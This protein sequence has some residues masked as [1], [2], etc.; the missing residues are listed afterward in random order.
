M[1]TYCNI[2]YVPKPWVNLYQVMVIHDLD[3]LGYHDLRN[4]MASSEACPSVRSKHTHISVSGKPESSKASLGRSVML[5][6]IGI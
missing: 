6:F 4:P 2:S 1:I 3:D 5:A